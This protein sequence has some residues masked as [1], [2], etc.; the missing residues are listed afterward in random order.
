MALSRKGS[1]KIV[2]RDTEYRWAIRSK[3]TY[4]QAAYGLSAT[5]TVEL[6]ENPQSTLSIGFPWARCD[7]WLE[8]QAKAITPAVISRCIQEALALGWKAD[9]PGV[10]EFNHIEPENT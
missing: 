5:A 3:H 2:V 1:R 9:D 8:A 10:F 6:Y 7:N 4:M